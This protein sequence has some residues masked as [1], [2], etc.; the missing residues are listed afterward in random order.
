M[1]VPVDF[2]LARMIADVCIG[3]ST[4]GCFY[5]LVASVAVLRFPHCKAA[6]GGR[7]APVTILKPLHGAE[8]ELGPRLGAFCRQEYT[9]A[10]QIVCGVHSADDPA[11]S[12][13][14]ELAASMPEA[15][16]SLKIDA[17]EH[18]KN[19]K[20]SNLANMMSEAQHPLLVMSDSDIEVGRDYLANIAAELQ[21]PNVLAVTCP[22]Y[23]VAAAGFWSQC[24]AL[25]INTHFLPG[26]IAGLALGLAR[27]CFGSTIA[28]HRST[29]SR[30]G[31]FES[32]A[33]CLADDYAIGESVR[34]LGYDVSI[35]SF[36]L[37]HRCDQPSLKSFVK[38]EI[39]AAR[40]IKAIDPVKYLGSVIMHPF[41]L[42][43]VAMA[44]GS[45]DTIYLAII[46]LLC[47]CALCLCVEHAF[48]LC[49]QTYKMIPILDLIAF[50]VFIF[51]FLDSRVSW[52]GFTYS[53]K[54]GN[55]MIAERS[56][57]E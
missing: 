12:I 4:I 33:D 57:G 35:T 24:A 17:R 9:A 19:R 21:K 48:S 46:A 18:G 29:L 42:A 52:H 37:G 8:P 30:I 32:V 15:A 20:V 40:T 53:T 34:A 49:K 28:M 41:P 51:S 13:V 14:R 56:S 54:P 6:P 23:G 27:P 10:V 2:D 7:Q 16:L 1:S 47:R 38:H 5:L 43:V 3:V 26:V 22:Y 55:Y 36:A 44:L 11:I 50:A 25:S 45:S 31:G 39:R